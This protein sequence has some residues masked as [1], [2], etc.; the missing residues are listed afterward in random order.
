MA[1]LSLKGKAASEFLKPYKLERKALKV[2]DRAKGVPTLRYGTDNDGNPVIVRSWPR[3]IDVDDSDLREIW[4]SETRHLRRLAGYPGASNYIAELRDSGVDDLGFYLVLSVGQRVPLRKILEESQRPPRSVEE[5][6]LLWKNLLR[7]AKGL[8]IL[9]LQGLLHRNL[10]T[11]AILSANDSEPDYQLTGFEW[12]MRIVEHD[13]TVQKRKS[14]NVSGE[15]SFTTDWTHFGAVVC[16][17]LS[18][19]NGKLFDRNVPSHTVIEGVSAEEIKLVRELMQI[20]PIDYLDGKVVADKIERIITTL[21][22]ATRSESPSF[23]LVVRIGQNTPL[24][25]QIRNASNKTVEINDFDAQEAFIKLDLMTPTAMLIEQGEEQRLVLRGEHLTYKLTDFKRGPAR[26]PSNWGLAYCDFAEPQAPLASSIVS[27]ISVV[28][29][30]ISI[31]NHLHAN[32]KAGTRSR[33][34]PWTTLLEQ[35]RPEDSSPASQITLRKSLMLAQVVD[36][37][38]AASEIFPIE[39]V[40]S[41]RP[42]HGFDD[43]IKIEIRPKP[44]KQ[45]E[46]LSE[47]MGL[48]SPSKRLREL[49]NDDRYARWTITDASTIGERSNNSTEWQFEKNGTNE[50]HY[51]FSG[52]RSIPQASRHF[53]VPLDSDGRDQQ[54]KRRMKSFAALAQHSELCSML[55]DPRIRIL[56]TH[57]TAIDDNGFQSLDSSKRQAMTEAIETFPLYMIQGPPGVGKTRLVKEIVRQ[58]LE[59]EPTT[60]ILLSAQSNHAVDHLLREIQ[61]IVDNDAGSGAVVVRCLPKDKRDD[62]AAF[63]INTQARSILGSLTKSNL[64]SDASDALK[65]RINGL[66]VSFGLQSQA[67]SASTQKIEV[68]RKAFEQL[69]LHSANLVFATTNSSDLERLLDERNQFDWTII[70]EAGKATGGELITPLLLSARRLMIGDHRQLPPFGSEQVLALLTN[71]SRVMKAIEAADDLIGWQLRD[72]TVEQILKDGTDNRPDR[73]K[74]F[75]LLCEE[76]SRNFLLFETLVETEFERMRNTARRPNIASRLNRQHRMHP[77]IAKVISHSFYGDLL[78]TDSDAIDRFNRSPNPIVLSPDSILPDGRFIWINTPW[79]QSTMG[80]KSGE[81]YPRYTNNGEVDTVEQI[82]R[83]VRSISPGKASL[84]ILSPYGRQV[85][86]LSRMMARHI[87]GSLRHIHEFKS[88]SGDSIFA[89]TVDSFQGNEADLVIVSLVR[90]NNHGSVGGALGFLSSPNR[91][92]VLL[93]RARHK[94]VVVGS[95]EFLRNILAL[96]K[97]EQV[98]HDLEFLRLMIECVDDPALCS[99]ITLD[100][101]AR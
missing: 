92:N 82:L 88:P 23:Q 20:F 97:P 59:K 101:S 57:E 17:V 19:P 9:H 21:S 64:F 47:S 91:M 44:D 32:Q 55:T 58:T 62:D 3:S 66:A 42:L 45:R 6:R 34:T 33:P 35:L 54:L 90:N 100:G 61:D 96:P 65:S 24:A 38:I 80:Q 63:S 76:A 98:S 4:R 67:S 77:E 84:A 41:E 18:L 85:A 95:L 74:E 53:L 36:Y 49:L 86:L 50:N 16:E 26:I 52:E 89:H 15:H 5:R 69:V 68:A 1:T 81:I 7:I 30:A 13:T 43:Q 12:S 72:E 28:T 71:P 22:A 70:E 14:N 87:N 60:R 25:T 39:L 94:L 37:L 31:T 73:S 8:E 48:K 99:I 27:Q 79:V 56:A 78:E 83:G 51:I 2:G 11:W 93:S 10:S 29:N 40:P 75:P 46:A